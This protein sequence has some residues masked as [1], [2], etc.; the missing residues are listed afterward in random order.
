MGLL[1]EVVWV[2]DTSSLINVKELVRPDRRTAVFAKLSL[3]CD[4][5]RLV[6]PQEVVDELKNGVRDGKPDL[7]LSWAKQNKKTGCRLGR[8]Y[9]ELRRVMNHPVARLTPDPDQTTGE[10]DA[11]PHVLATALKAS[12]LGG[13][14]VVVTQESRKVPPQV[15][16]NVAAGSLGLP[17]VNL[18]ALLIALDIWTDDMRN[19]RQRR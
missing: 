19:L 11:D 17:S 18:Y 8:C 16:L 9:D 13:T 2:V 14:A 6:F 5:H 4:K 10:D 12:S 7:P 3:V 1:A 15:P